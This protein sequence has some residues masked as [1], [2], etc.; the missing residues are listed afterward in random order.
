MQC[1]HSCG[2]DTLVYDNTAGEVFPSLFLVP[3]F[4]IIHSLLPVLLLA[5]FALLKGVLLFAHISA[6]KDANGADVVVIKEI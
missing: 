4:Q 6:I 1:S 5:S 2:D 3:Y